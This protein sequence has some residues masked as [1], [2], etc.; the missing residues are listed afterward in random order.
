MNLWDSPFYL[1]QLVPT[2]LSFN[3]ID[4]QDCYTHTRAHTHMHT[5]THAHRLRCGFQGPVVFNKYFRYVHLFHG[6]PRW[7][8]DS[9]HSL[10]DRSYSYSP[11]CGLWGWIDA[12]WFSVAMPVILDLR[13]PG[14][15]RWSYPV[16]G[17]AVGTEDCG[18]AGRTAYFQGPW[19]G[20]L[21]QSEVQGGENHVERWQYD[22]FSPVLLIMKDSIGSSRW[23]RFLAPE[24]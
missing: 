24:E 20:R 3:S 12:R 1:T 5:H 2:W 11:L 7:Q 22:L 10:K 17:S 15:Q 16:D 14:L 23:G 9:K 19:L 21:W 18:V 6:L 13:A 8:H 4:Q